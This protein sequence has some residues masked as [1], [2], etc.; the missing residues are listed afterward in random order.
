MTAW[1]GP[2]DN[3]TDSDIPSLINS[4]LDIPENI[5]PRLKEV[6]NKNRGDFGLDGHLGDYPVKVP[7]NLKEGSQPVSLP[8]YAASPLKREVIDKQVAS[9]LE[10]DIIE[11]SA[12]PWGFPVVVIFQKGKPRF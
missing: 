8:M 12:S 3:N 9:W 2:L 5:L 6:L 11:P 1:P 7:L 4:G 10:A